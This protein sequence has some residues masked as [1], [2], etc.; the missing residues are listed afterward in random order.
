LVGVGLA[1]HFD[2]ALPD[3][4]EAFDLRAG[5]E[6]AGAEQVARWGRWWD[7]A[8][9]QHPLLTRYLKA[10]GLSLTPPPTLRLARWGDKPLMLARVQHPTHGLVG[11]H[12]T[13]LEQ[14][15]SGRKEKRLAAGSHPLGGAIRLFEHQPGQPLALT[16]GVETALAVHQSTAWPVWA[17]V[18][19]IG[20]ERVV[21]PIEAHEA[22]IAADHDPA[23]LEAARKLARRLLA[24][25]RRVRLAV[26]PRAGADWL[27]AVAGGAA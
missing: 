3:R 1:A 20:L 6:Q 8:K 4:L 13:F 24:E 2:R 26:P 9:P 14:D 17:A 5:T 18:S 25:G 7:A 21:L 27:D 10:R 22:V 23:G 15:G 11:M 12:L 16:E 19:A